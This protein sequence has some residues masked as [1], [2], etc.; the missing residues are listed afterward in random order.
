MKIFAKQGHED[1]GVK[2]TVGIKEFSRNEVI[3]ASSSPAYMILAV[4]AVV[5]TQQGKHFWSHFSQYTSCT[6]FKNGGGGCRKTKEIKCK[7]VIP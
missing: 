7:K 5:R 4:V 3:F 6:F 2:E 1:S